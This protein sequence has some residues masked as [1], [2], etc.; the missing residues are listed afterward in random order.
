MITDLT[1]NL[2]AVQ[3]EENLINVRLNGS[4]LVNDFEL[5]EVNQ[6]TV[7]L[8][9]NVPSGIS[10]ITRLEL[11]G[12]TG[13]LSDSNLFVPVEVDTRFRYRMRVV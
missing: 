12:E 6:N 10:Q 8:E 7:T 5:S 13:V 1:K 2:I 9:F 3:Y 11:L 4:V